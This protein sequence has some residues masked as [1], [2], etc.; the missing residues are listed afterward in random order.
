VNAPAKRRGKKRIYDY[1]RPLPKRVV[2]VL[3]RLRRGETLC[4]SFRPRAVG[5]AGDVTLFWLEPSGRQCGPASALTLVKSG[6]LAPK[7]PGLFGSQDAQSWRY[8][9]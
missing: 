9:P 5:E 1:P 4:R 6:M 3:E 2:T 8:A 7:D